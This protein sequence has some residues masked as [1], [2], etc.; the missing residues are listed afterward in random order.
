VDNLQSSTPDHLGQVQC[1]TRAFYSKNPALATRELSAIVSQTGVHARF[2]V[3]SDNFRSVNNQPDSFELQAIHVFKT[4]LIQPPKDQAR[5]VETYE[6]NR[7]RYA[8]PVKVSEGCMRCHGDPK[9]APREVI[10]KY[11]EQRAFYYRLGDIRGVITIDLPVP[12]LA[13]ASPIMNAYSLALIAAAFLANFFLFKRIV[14]DRITR[15]TGIT[16][17]MVHG[18]LNAEVSD[19]YR[20]DSGDEIDKLYQA[21]DLMK[22][23]VRIALDKLKDH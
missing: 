7:Y 1:G 12:S 5:F 22:R 9:D 23:S 20:K 17:K 16:E 21:V 19:H 13:A 2:R 11:G 6:G 14:V 3:S 8:I 10:D 4:G 15:L 18:D